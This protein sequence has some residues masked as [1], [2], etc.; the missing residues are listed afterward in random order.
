MGHHSWLGLSSAGVGGMHRH[1]L[2]HSLLQMPLP[3]LNSACWASEVPTFHCEVLHA[4]ANLSPECLSSLTSSA[5]GRAGGRAVPSA[6]LQSVRCSRLTTGTSA[7]YFTKSISSSQTLPSFQAQCQAHFLF[8]FSPA[9]FCC[10]FAEPRFH[11][12]QP[13]GSLGHQSWP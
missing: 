8:D 12:A 13:D 11:V 10:L 7:C 4:L 5:L 9:Y 2:L 3:A 1:A 6:P